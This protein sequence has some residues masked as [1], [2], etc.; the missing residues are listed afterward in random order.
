M[1]VLCFIIHGVGTQDQSFS[2]PLQRGIDR[3]LE[4]MIAKKS[5][6]TNGERWQKLRAADLVDYEPIY[7]ADIGSP[8]QTKLYRKIYPALFA[9]GGRLKRFF[10]LATQFAPAR[11]LSIRLVGDVFGYLG[12]FQTAIKG[13]VFGQV[14]EKLGPKLESMEPFTIILI[15][16]SLGSVILYDVIGEFLRNDYMKMNLLTERTSVF[17]MGSPLSLFSLVTEPVPIHF[18]RWV[19]FLHPR[20][21]IAYPMSGVFT[22]VQDVPLFRLSWRPLALHSLYW[23]DSAVHR[24][25]AAEIIDHTEKDLAAQE[26]PRTPP[27]PSPEITPAAGQ[28]RLSVYVGDFHTIPFADLIRNAREIDICVVYGGHWI[29]QNAGYLV[30]ALCNPNAVVRV[31]TLS[32][33]SPA[34]VGFSHHFSGMPEDEIR[35]RIEAGKVEL[36]KALEEARRRVAKPGRLHIYRALNIINHSFYRFDD[37]IIY[38]PRPIASNK[39]AATPLPSLVFRNTSQ[40][41]DFFSWLMR[42]FELVVKTQRDAVTHFD[43]VDQQPIGAATSA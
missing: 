18:R 29:Q 11:E 12:K 7:W 43:S 26:L 19:N 27:S 16:H 30:Q 21:P 39:L 13:K 36:L 5:K 3:K 35:K 15:G 4:K 25:I 38:T 23:H 8:E 31:C 41:N 28:A 20:D 33:D 17:T 37:V 10:Q 24:R 14:S 42:D 9:S 1:S 40:P 6:E 22:Y 2:D 34:L 32:P